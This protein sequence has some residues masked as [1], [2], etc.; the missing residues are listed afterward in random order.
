MRRSEKQVDPA[1]GPVQQFASELRRLRIMAGRPTYRQLAALAHYSHTT[2]SRA[3]S[4]DTL[5]FPVGCPGVCCG[6]RR[7]PDRWS[8]RWHEVAR[9]PGV[10]GGDPAVSSLRS[11][12][13]AREDSTY[14]GRRA[15]IDRV[16]ALLS[17]RSQRRSVDRPADHGVAGPH[18]G[19]A[20]ACRRR[21]PRFSAVC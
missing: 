5:P 6:V 4:G 8:Q 16:V 21:R 13:Q 14:V 1:E 19:A 17:D 12:L 7:D 3:A 20:R 9:Q 18:T 10:D 15:E 11:L 2:L